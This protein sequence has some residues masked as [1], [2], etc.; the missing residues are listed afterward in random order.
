MFFSPKYFIVQARKNS[1][2]VTEKWITNILL[3][4]DI[5]C[6]LNRFRNQVAI[7]VFIWGEDGNKETKKKWNSLLLSTNTWALSEIL[8]YMVDILAEALRQL[9]CTEILANL[10]GSEKI[11]GAKVS[12]HFWA[13][14]GALVLRNRTGTSEPDSWQAEVVSG[15]VHIAELV[16]FIRNH[17]S[18]MLLILSKFAGH[19]QLRLA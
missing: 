13:R 17:F 9:N 2:L 14:E 12:S 4:C 11:N 18:A 8:V 10:R 7:P 1:W 19:G 6:N 15:S 5:S 16:L 3:F